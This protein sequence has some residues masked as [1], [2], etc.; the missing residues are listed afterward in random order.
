MG[1]MADLPRSEDNTGERSQDADAASR[2]T[3]WLSTDSRALAKAAPE[4]TES[5]SPGRHTLLKPLP[6]NQVSDTCHSRTC[7]IQ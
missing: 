2:P 5:Q 4:N 1:A 6:P 3:A 7:Q